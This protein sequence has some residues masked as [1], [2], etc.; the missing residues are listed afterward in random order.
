MLVKITAE[1]SSMTTCGHTFTSSWNLKMLPLKFFWIKWDEPLTC[2]KTQERNSLIFQVLHILAALLEPNKIGKFVRF[3]SQQFCSTGD[4]YCCWD[5]H[6]NPSL[7]TVLVL[8]GRRLHQIPF[9]GSSKG[10]IKEYFQSPK[11]LLKFHQLNFVLWYLWSSASSS[12][13][14]YDINRCIPEPLS[15][16]K[17]KHFHQSWLKNI[18]QVRMPHTFTFL[19]DCCSFLQSSY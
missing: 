11:F 3:L 5:F 12:Q 19:L 2:I 8:R 6:S 15:E 7:A 9:L 1:L 4:K 10:R 17:Y 18:C 13:G 16:A 14:S